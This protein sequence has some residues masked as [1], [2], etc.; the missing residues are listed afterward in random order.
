[1]S[2][3]ALIMM[4]EMQFPENM[5]TV[6]NLTVVVKIKIILYFRADISSMNLS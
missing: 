6:F 5:V 1:M 3:I 2:K 4:E